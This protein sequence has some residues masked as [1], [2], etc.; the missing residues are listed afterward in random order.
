MDTK[1]GLLEKEISFFE[2]NK[3]DYLSKYKDQFVLIKGEQFLG[4]YTTETEAY[5]AG[6]EKFGNEPFLIKQVI[7]KEE[8]ISFPALT[9]GAINVSL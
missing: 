6:V 7:E 5:T 1:K 3:Q 4:S 8:G 2:K 9:V